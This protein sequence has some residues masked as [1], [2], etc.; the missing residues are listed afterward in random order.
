MEKVLTR[1]IDNP[2]SHRLDVYLSQGGYKALSIALSKKPEEIVQEVKSANLYGRGGAGFPAGV[3]WGFLP[4]DTQRP[5]YLCVNAD[6][7]EPGTFKDRLIMERNPH[8]L[9]EGMI[10]TSYAIGAHTG[11]IYIRGELSKAARIL[12]Q[13]IQECYKKGF[14]GE[15]VLNREFKLD[16]IVHRGAGA[17]IC[18]EET[19]MLSSIEGKRGHPR[20][21]P[22]FP[23]EK[24]LFESPT[25]V[26]NVETIAC[27][28]GIIL[29]GAK[30]FLNLG[31][32]K[33]GGTKLY[34]ISGHVLRPG[35]YE[36]PMGIN[37]KDLIYTYGGG[38]KDGKKLKAVIPGGLSTPVLTKDEID[39]PMSFEGLKAKGSMFGTGCPIV[40]HEE[41]CMVWVAGI[42]MR[43]Y[44]HESCG[45]CIPCREGL[46]WIKNQVNKIERGEGKLKDIELIEDLANTITGVTLC[47]MGDAAT[48]PIL[49]YLKKFREEFYQHIK[50]KHCP[51]KSDLNLRA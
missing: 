23:A 43:F 19:A 29:H 21:K 32:G 5:V 7:G 38:I 15:R 22:P 50:L 49:A 33:E 3:K 27:V 42:A 36:L 34:G 47:P 16:F 17:Y 35:I 13:A 10:I 14:L 2:N 1:N 8:L 37:L 39:L 48:M 25:I 4:K 46:Y 40:I 26:N 51:F 30:W 44:V 6:E 31:R 24:G 28:P 18:G 20:I 45:K 11:F 12:E 9:L 41:T